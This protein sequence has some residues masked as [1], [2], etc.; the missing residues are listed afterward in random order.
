MNLIQKLY[1]VFSLQMRVANKDTLHVAGFHVAFI[2]FSSLDG[3]WLNGLCYHFPS[4]DTERIY[5][6]SLG[7]SEGRDFLRH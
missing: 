6:I 5:A 3:T 2:S 1:S 7:C 4:V